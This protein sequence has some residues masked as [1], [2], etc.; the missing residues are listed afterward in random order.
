MM[1]ELA[2]ALSKA[3]NTQINAHIDQLEAG[4]RVPLEVAQQRGEARQAKD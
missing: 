4:S 3:T 2:S 1:R